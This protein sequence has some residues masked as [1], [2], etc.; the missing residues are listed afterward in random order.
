[1]NLA[2]KIATARL[3]GR[4]GLQECSGRGS[5]DPLRLVGGNPTLIPSSASCEVL[6]FEVI[7]NPMSLATRADLEKDVRIPPSLRIHAEVLLFLF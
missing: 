6:V 4:Q 3:I 1:M 7:V 5:R 2:A